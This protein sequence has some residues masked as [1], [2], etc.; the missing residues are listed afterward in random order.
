MMNLHVVNQKHSLELVLIPRILTPHL[1]NH[2]KVS[3]YLPDFAHIVPVVFCLDII[4]SQCTYASI[5]FIHKHRGHQGDIARSFPPY[6]GSG[7][8]SSAREDHCGAYQDCAHSIRRIF[9]VASDNRRKRG[10]RV[11]EGGGVGGE[12]GKMGGVE[13]TWQ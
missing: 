13:K 4:D 8:G 12:G 1:N 5:S 7:I 11:F 3:R 9:Y 2:L 10:W 6:D